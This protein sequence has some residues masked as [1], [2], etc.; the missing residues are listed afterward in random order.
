M[1]RMLLIAVAALIPAVANAQDQQASVP[2]N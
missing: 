2:T 1:L